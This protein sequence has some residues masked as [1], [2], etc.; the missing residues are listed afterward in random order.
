[1]VTVEY[2]GKD[3]NWQDETTIYW[4]T[5]NGKDYGTEIRFS[6]SVYGL[7]DNN[8]DT[9]LLD[10]DGCPMVEGNG[11]YI[12]VYKAIHNNITDIIERG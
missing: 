12:A 9:T 6:D 1:M 8:G 7:A 10:C 5:L 4:F 2:N 3:Q 11:E